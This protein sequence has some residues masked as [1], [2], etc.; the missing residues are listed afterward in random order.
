MPEG[1]KF[2]I[3]M[4]L[5]VIGFGQFRIVKGSCGWLLPTRFVAV[6]LRGS[7]RAS[8]SLKNNVEPF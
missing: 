3:C 7:V 4:H 1:L 5:G 6:G 8:I 2:K